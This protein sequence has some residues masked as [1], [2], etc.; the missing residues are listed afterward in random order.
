M[1]FITL[2]NTLRVCYIKTEL[3]QW[4]LSWWPEGLRRKGLY[5][6]SLVPIP[7]TCGRD[8]RYERGFDWAY[9]R[10]YGPIW[11]LKWK[12]LS[13]SIFSHQ[14]HHCQW[15]VSSHSFKLHS[16]SAAPFPCY[17]KTIFDLER[18][19]GTAG[20][21]NDITAIQC[22]LASTTIGIIYQLI[23]ILIQ[24]K[25]GASQSKVSITNYSVYRSYY[26]ILIPPKKGALERDYYKIWLP[27]RPVVGL[28]S[29]FKFLV[30]SKL[31]HDIAKES[32]DFGIVEWCAP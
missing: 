13:W 28:A 15:Q 5:V 21:G 32:K 25:D 20:T 17:F 3:R 7:S 9:V 10:K 23:L 4:N 31:H 30:L 29:N 1:Y 8:S 26:A 11:F 16:E 12:W 22:P 2:F 27:L 19:S 18:V 24:R 6:S 14:T